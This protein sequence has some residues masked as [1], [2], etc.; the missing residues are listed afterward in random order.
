MTFFLLH[1]N[2]ICAQH[3]HLSKIVHTQHELLSR[4]HGLSILYHSPVISHLITNTKLVRDVHLGWSS[5]CN[6]REDNQR[7][8]YDSVNFAP[9]NTPI[10][11]TPFCPA[12]VR[13]HFILSDAVNQ[14]SGPDCLHAGTNPHITVYCTYNV[15]ICI[16]K[17]HLRLNSY[18]G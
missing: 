18:R 4:N 3:E 12:E 7:P 9:I 2:L 10:T 15:Q 6:W 8:G 13:H 14:I 5:W 16:G 17:D 1:W 11:Q